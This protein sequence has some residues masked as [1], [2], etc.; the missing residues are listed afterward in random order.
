M[1][2]EEVPKEQI[3]KSCKIDRRSLDRWVLRWNKGGYEAIVNQK[4]AGC[5]MAVDFT[6]NS[7]GTL[8]AMAHVLYNYTKH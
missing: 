2:H 4:R 6:P 8:Q 3:L 5:E 7:G 1:C